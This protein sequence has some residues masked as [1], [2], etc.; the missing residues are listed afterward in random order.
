MFFDIENKKIVSRADIKD[1]HV[2]RFP[3]HMDGN[4]DIIDCPKRGEESKQTFDRRMGRILFSMRRS[5][6]EKGSCRLLFYDF[7]IYLAATTYQ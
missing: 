4:P 2:I 6:L 3:A 5:I 1:S 7:N